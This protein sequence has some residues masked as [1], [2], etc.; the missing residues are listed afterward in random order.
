MPPPQMQLEAVIPFFF[1]SFDLSV[2]KHVKGGVGDSDIGHV[3]AP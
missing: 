2:R 1:H 3:C